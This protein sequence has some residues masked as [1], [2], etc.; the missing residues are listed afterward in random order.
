MNGN[1]NYSGRVEICL[2]GRWGT[3]CDDDWDNEDATV[4]CTELGFPGKGRARARARSRARA[5]ARAGI[6]RMQQLSVLS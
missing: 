6:T 3:V 1:G 2:N 5:R 4:V